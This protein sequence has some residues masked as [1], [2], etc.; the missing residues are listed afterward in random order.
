MYPTIIQNVPV[1]FASFNLEIHEVN[2]ID[3]SLLFQ[4]RL[5]I[6]Y[7]RGVQLTEDIWVERNVQKCKMDH[8]KERLKLSLIPKHGM[9]GVVAAGMHVERA[10]GVVYLR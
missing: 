3:A 5:E 1:I 10:S 8:L 7:G 4:N 6:V 2:S 9:L